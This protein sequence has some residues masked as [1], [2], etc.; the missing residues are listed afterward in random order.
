[1]T[2]SIT[3]SF[4]LLFFFLVVAFRLLVFPYIREWPEDQPETRRLRRLDSPGEFFKLVS[5]LAGAY[6][7][8][9]RVSRESRPNR[10]MKDML[11]LVVSGAA[12]CALLSYIHRRTA[13]QHGLP[14]DLVRDLLA[15]R[16][17]GVSSADLPALL[18]A[19]RLVENGGAVSGGD[20]EAVSEAYGPAMATEME[21][22]LKL[23]YF[24]SLCSNMVNY[25]ERGRVPREER[26]RIYLAYLLA[27]PVSWFMLRKAVFLEEY[28]T[29]TEPVE[30]RNGTT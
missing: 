18:F 5:E 1:M 26:S 3:S 21:A 14:Q 10:R 4:V 16:F 13:L 25:Y 6:P 19:R 2:A 15:G 9:K 17:E 12:E 24:S 30:D 7:M 11:R 29:R 28:Y 27:R 23:V 22:F 20:L 8:T